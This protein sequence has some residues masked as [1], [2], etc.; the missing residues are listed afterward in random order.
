MVPTVLHTGCDRVADVML[1]HSGRDI[2]R[3]SPPPLLQCCVVHCGEIVH[4]IQYADNR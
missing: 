1:S 4:P 3:E 2:P